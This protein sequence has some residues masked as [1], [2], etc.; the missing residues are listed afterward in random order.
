[1]FVFGGD[2]VPTLLHLADVHLEAKLRFLGLAGRS[3]RENIRHALARSV[4]VAIERRVDAVVVAGDLF[5]NNRPSPATVE[6]V[7]QQWGRLAA[8]GIAVRLLPGTH[9]ALTPG[10][11]YASGALDLGERVRVYQGR[12][13]GGWDRE[14]LPG[15]GI[16]ILARPTLEKGSRL[17]ALDGLPPVTPGAR[18]RVA[19]VHGALETAEALDDDYLIDPAAVASS[20]LD[21]VAAGHWHAFRQL[22]FGR[23]TL[24]YPGSPEPVSP[25]PRGLGVAVLVHLDEGHPPGPPRLEPVVIGRTRCDVLVWDVTGQSDSADLERELER[26]ADPDLILLVELRGLRAARST[27]DAAAVEER[28]APEFFS[29]AVND[30]AAD[31]VDPAQLPAATGTLTG[32]FAARLARRAAQ[33]ESAE[34]RRAVAEALRLGLALLE[35]REVW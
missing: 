11:V 23:T 1:L 20:G 27:L 21:Y 8:A 19:L 6:F 25:K 16:E 4:D 17:Q 30:L 28:W 12:E 5:D 9:D 14:L 22:T 34:E 24:C 33:A 18:W 26:R 2:A 35:G 10:G 31:E 3:Q 32:L 13:A 15:T 7:R 29:L